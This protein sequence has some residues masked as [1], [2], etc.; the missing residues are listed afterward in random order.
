MKQLRVESA[1]DETYA[2]LY[3]AAMAVAASFLQCAKFDIKQTEAHHL[4]IN[5]LIT[6]RVRTPG[7]WVANWCKS[8]WVEDSGKGRAR[9]LRFRKDS[10]VESEVRITSEL[11]KGKGAT[12]PA[13]TF[14]V[15]PKEL[16][17]IALYHERLLGELRKAAHANRLK[18]RSLEYRLHRDRKAASSCIAR[19]DALETLQL[20]IAAENFKEAS[21]G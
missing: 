21:A 6:V 8:M 2:E 16:R 4:K 5:Y 3:E 7:C 13:S 14:K 15:L 1:L 17:G 20:M 12:Y 18:K 19:L 11:P 10:P 9:S